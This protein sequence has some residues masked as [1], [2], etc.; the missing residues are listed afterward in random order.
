[1]TH[2][3]GCGMTSPKPSAL[4][5]SPDGG[6]MSMHLLGASPH[7]RQSY[8]PKFLAAMLCWQQKCDLQQGSRIL[9]KTIVEV[10][11]KST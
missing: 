10:Q 9:I 5:I 8:G 1:M 4:I 7:H 2:S 6:V 3:F 11:Y